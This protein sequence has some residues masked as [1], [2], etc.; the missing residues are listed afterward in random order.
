MKKLIYAAATA[1]A[2]AVGVGS[3][4]LGDALDGG[5]LAALRER[6]LRLLASVAEASRS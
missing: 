4:L 6:A 3:G 1:L 5:S 2:L